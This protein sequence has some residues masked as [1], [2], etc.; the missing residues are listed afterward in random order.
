MRVGTWGPD[1]VL[2]VKNSFL[3][4]NLELNTKKEKEKKKRSELTL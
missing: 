3:E 1:L 4:E 2:G